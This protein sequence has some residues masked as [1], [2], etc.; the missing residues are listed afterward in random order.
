M[1]PQ[2]M[3]DQLAN[4]G[5]A[6]SMET[7]EVI[8]DPIALIESMRAVG[9][10][11]EAAIAD[12]VDNSISARANLIEI[13]YDASM[14]PF[15]AILDDGCGMAPDG[16]MILDRKFLAQTLPT[17]ASLLGESGHPLGTGNVAKCLGNESGIV[18]GF[19]HTGF[20]V[21][22]H[23]FLGLEMFSTIPFP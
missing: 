15:V 20:E 4:G 6:K 2:F 8:P 23:V 21:S 7:L 12:L 17:Q 16:L 9:Y 1:S 5:K 22:H 18:T 10:S 3:H 14:D 19:L 11:V 13:K